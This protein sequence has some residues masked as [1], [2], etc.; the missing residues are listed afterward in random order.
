MKRRHGILSA[1]LALP[2]TAALMSG[3]ATL[4]SRRGAADIAGLLPEDAF[5]YLRVEPTAQSAALWSSLLASAGRGELPA[6]DFARLLERMDRVFAAATAATEAGGKAS[7][8]LAAV[9]SFPSSVIELNLGRSDQWAKVRVPRSSRRSWRTPRTYW[10]SEEL[11]VEM[12]LPDR[13]LLL[14]ST[15]A[16][17]AMIERYGGEGETDTSADGEVPD[18]GDA[19]PRL[20][21]RML[22]DSAPELMAYF[23]DFQSERM[24]R[25]LGRGLPVRSLLLEAVRID[26]G[27]ELR[28]EFVLEREESA[29]AFDMALRFVLLYLMKQGDIQG[30][31]KRLGSLS[32][33]QEGTTIRLAGLRLTDQEIAALLTVF[34]AGG[35]RG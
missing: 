18:T 34:L 11:G 6:E 27:V 10:A 16:V 22:A 25:L 1:V 31:V 33:E 20:P 4:P 8:D 2:L 5:V 12:C 29:K 26:Q 19:A 35:M 9:G 7:L 13:H 3:C 24:E 14:L 32:I 15:T 21:Q 30:G 23:P 28:G 17:L